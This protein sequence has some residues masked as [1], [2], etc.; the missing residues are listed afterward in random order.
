MM[1]QQKKITFP[2]EVEAFFARNHEVSWRPELLVRSPGR[3]GRWI[4]EESDIPWLELDIDVPHEAMYQEALGV[5]HMTIS[6]NYKTLFDEDREQT[7]P[8]TGWDTVC[9]HGLEGDPFKFDR[10]T[11]YG[12]P[13]EDEAPYGWTEVADQCPTIKAFLES[14][15]YAK[16]YRARITKLRAGGY[17]AP[18]IGRTQGAKYNKKINFALNHPEGFEFALEGHGLVPWE[19]GKGFW[20]NVDKNYHSVINRSHTDRFHLITMGRPDWERL[21]PLLEKAYYHQ[22]SPHHE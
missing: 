8:Q 1:N 18:H 5:A 11:E 21:G 2:P 19:A 12:Y 7:P 3:S 6:Q 10:A 22:D 9:V 16:L 13:D 15:P 4:Y 17:A 20:L 14:L